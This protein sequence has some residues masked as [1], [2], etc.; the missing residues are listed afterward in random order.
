[1][2]KTIV[3]NLFAGPGSGKSTTCAGLF[4]H[5]KNGG[6]N[7]EMALEYA[8]DKVWEE[9][10]HVLSNQIYVFG[11]QLHKLWRLNGKVDIII[12]DSPLPISI[13]YDKTNNKELEG[14]VI[15]QFNE[16]NN[17]NFFISRGNKY[18]PAGR[19]QSEEEAK[20]LDKE[21]INVLDNHNIP[22]TIV[23]RD[24]AVT[25]IIHSIADRIKA[26]DRDIVRKGGKA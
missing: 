1:M 14:L 10:L 7:C 26:A 22:Y 2:R 9:S 21:M 11:K 4:Y 16:F 12:T 25:Q 5:F 20:E 15:Q 13:M 24:E 19:M 18:N 3:I 6:I 23:N 17:Y 8:K